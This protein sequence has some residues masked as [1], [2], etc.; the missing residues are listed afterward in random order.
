MFILVYLGG[1]GY[2]ESMVKRFF[3]HLEAIHVVNKCIYVPLLEN[4]YADLS[5]DEL[6]P[7]RY[8]EYIHRK[9]GSPRPYYDFIDNIRAQRF[10]TE[11]YKYVFFGTSMGCY[12]I[13]NY[14][15]FYPRVVYAMIWLEPTMCGGDY[16][17]LKD[18][19]AGRGNKEWI[20]ML[21]DE[22]TDHEEWDSST[23]VI[24]IAVS[25]DFDNSFRK[26][27]KLGIIYTTLNNE[28]KPYTE[29][30]LKAKEGF[31]EELKKKGYHYL[32]KLIDGPHTADLY[33]KYIGGIAD[34]VSDVIKS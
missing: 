29:L 33:P 30:Q 23:K 2:T 11:V 28:G 10:N 16:K 17:Y 8:S 15:H 25:N 21:Y 18:F 26:S 3:G 9:I 4:V 31:L 13:Q 32:F 14:A 20:N 24:D 6:S 1:N 19:E 12:H 22:K 7:K 34:F 5:Y 27:I